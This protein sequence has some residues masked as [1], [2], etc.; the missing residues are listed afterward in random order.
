M[1]NAFSDELSN[2]FKFASNKKHNSTRSQRQFDKKL[3]Q[4]FY[5]GE[6][7]QTKNKGLSKSKPLRD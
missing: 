2:L 5:F 3:C 4:Y 1:L 7:G 6:Q